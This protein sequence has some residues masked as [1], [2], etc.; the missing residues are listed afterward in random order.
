MVYGSSAFGHAHQRPSGRAFDKLLQTPMPTPQ[1]V[2]VRLQDRNGLSRLREKATGGQQGLVKLYKCSALSFWEPHQLENA[3]TLK[4]V[5]IT[6]LRLISNE[7]KNHNT[8][9]SITNHNTEPWSIHFC[10]PALSVRWAQGAGCSQPA[11]LLCG[12]LQEGLGFRIL[13]LG[14]RVSG[15]GFGVQFMGLEHIEYKEAVVFARGPVSIRDVSN[16]Y[17]HPNSLQ[18]RNLK[19]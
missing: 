16:P 12:G 18:T 4:T 13:G 11:I 7:K 14:L 17:V 10:R 8:K 19:P 1:T 15:L 3:P 5:M 9:I 6:S 2:S